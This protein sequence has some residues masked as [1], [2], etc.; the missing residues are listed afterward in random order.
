[1]KYKCYECSCCIEGPCYLINQGNYKL[2]SCYYGGIA[3]FQEY[4][5][6]EIDKVLKKLNRPPRMS[7]LEAMEKAGPSDTIKRDGSFDSFRSVNGKLRRIYTVPQTPYTPHY[8]E[9]WSSVT[10]S[11]TLLKSNDWYIEEGDQ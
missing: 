7:L 3:V 11:T 10:V 2:T 9:E 6:P 4:T 5:S 8:E 1:M